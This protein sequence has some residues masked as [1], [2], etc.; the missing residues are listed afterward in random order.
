MNP[1]IFITGAPG[2]L[3]TRIVRALIYGFESDYKTNDNLKVDPKN[4]HCFAFGCDSAQSI[5]LISKDIHISDGDLRN[6]Q[7][8]QKFLKDSADGILIHAAAVIHPRRV[9]DFYDLN[10]QGTEALLKEA[11]SKKMKRAV[12]ISSN[13]PC[14]CNSPNLEL[15][16]ELSPY[17]PYM[18]YGRSKMLMEKSVNKLSAESSMETVVIRAPW[19]YGPGQPPRQSLFFSMIKNGS[20]P[21]VGSGLNKRSMGFVDNLAY[22][23]LL[24]TFSKTVKNPLYWIADEHPYTMNE[25]VET[26]EDLLENE[27]GITC[28]KKRLRL[29]SL[30]SDVAWAIDKSIQSIGLYNQKIHVL[31]EMNKSIA[32]RIELAKKDLEYHPPISLKHGMRRSI[33]WCI[34]NGIKI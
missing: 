32:C 11:I 30:V 8:I 34:E 23:V 6:T 13:S 24:A 33:Q 14:G 29:P 7:D 20:F 1:K 31:S 17:N 26:I 2:W 18:H 4:V 27:F 9:K 22:G 5:R 12:V 3:G 25:I 16:D 10:V 21:I 15:F 28:A 19:F